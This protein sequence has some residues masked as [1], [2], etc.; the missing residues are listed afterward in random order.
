MR[1]IYLYVEKNGFLRKVA[2]DMAYFGTYKKIRL[3]KSHFE[4]NLYFRYLN[5]IKNAESFD[6]YYLTK[7][8]ISSEDEN[9]Y[10]FKFPFKVEQILNVAI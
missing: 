10:Y 9:F 8:K 5:D 3:L 6:N 4:D 7:D 2:I 1:T